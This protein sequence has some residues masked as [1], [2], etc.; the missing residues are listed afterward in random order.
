MVG[1]GDWALGP[2]AHGAGSLL[3]ISHYALRREMKSSIA[4]PHHAAPHYNRLQ[5][6]ATDCN[7]LLRHTTCA[8]RRKVK[9]SM[10]SI[11]HLRCP[12][13]SSNAEHNTPVNALCDTWHLS[14]KTQHNHSIPVSQCVAVCGGVVQCGAVWCCVVQC[15][16]LC[17][18]VAQC[19]A[20]FR[21][22]LQCVAVCC[23]VLQFVAECCSNAHQ[24]AL[25]R[26]C[27]VLQC[28]EQCCSVL[29]CGAV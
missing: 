17:C 18:S 29:Q 24:C 6:T 7:R 4:H 27:S 13:H 15:V 25:Y 12:D 1:Y 11:A 26:P 2:W 14:C 5:Q 22:V 19:D 20:V 28:V 21:S 10:A 16:A 3:R 9:S 8:L 23:S